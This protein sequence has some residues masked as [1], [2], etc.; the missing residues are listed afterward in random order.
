[1]NGFAHDRTTRRMFSPA[2][3]GPLAKVAMAALVLSA[4]FPAV[5]AQTETASNGKPSARVES[6]RERLNADLAAVRK[7]LAAFQEATRAK[8]VA[9]A[10]DLGA[11]RRDVVSL[12]KTFETQAG[13]AGEAERQMGEIQADIAH[14]ESVIAF[15]DSVVAESRRAFET[16]ISTPERQRRDAALVAIDSALDGSTPTDRLEASPTLLKLIEEQLSDQLGGT[17]FGGTVVDPDGVVVDGTFAEIGPISYFA[18]AD[19]SVSGLVVQ[20]LNSASPGLFT[21]FA[22]PE[23]FPQIHALCQTGRGAVPLDVTLGSAIK[24]RQT[25]DSLLEHMRKGG[26]V[27]IPL[28]ALAA[29]CAFI[30][31]YKLLSLSRVSYRGTEAR[32]SAIVAALQAGHVQEALADADR[33]RPPLGP[34]IHEGITHCD[35]PKEHIEEIMY[36]RVLYQLPALE[37]FLAPLAVCASAA[38]LLGLLGTV[39]GM[40]HTFHLITVFGTG[41]AKLLS[42]GISEALITTEFGLIIAIPTLLVHAYLSRRVRKTIAATQQA[43]IMFVNGLKLKQ[44]P[45]AGRPAE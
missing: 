6:A 21:D 13:K 36:E 43:A 16:R 38:P 15:A 8:R 22:A 23:A 28:L 19:A 35:A 39:T 2:M 17:S 3:R 20:R 24:L 1:M 40:I 42:A 9:M 12:E 33:L 30:A 25:K 10:R 4:I 29:T 34:V 5:L 11:C 41:D 45:E 31:L 32:I 14:L 44:H 37:R 18:A 26:I 7:E 27:M